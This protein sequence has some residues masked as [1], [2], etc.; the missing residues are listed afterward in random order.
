MKEEKRKYST[1]SNLRYIYTDMWKFDK[2]LSIFAA[3][4]V[5]LTVASN[6]VVIFL[7]AM[8]IQM[9]ELQFSPQDMIK[10]ILI[11]FSLYGILQAVYTYFEKRNW[12][13]YIEYRGGHVMRIITRKCMS[14]DYVQ[15][16]DEK[17]QKLMENATHAVGGND[18]GLEGILRTNIKVA[19][20]SIG[21]VLY[22]M[23]I[24]NIHYL[25][26]CML[27]GISAIQY[28]CYGFAKRYE[29]SNRDK[30]AKL[31]VTKR[32]F[33]QQAYDVAA[34]KDI[35]LYQ[36]QDWLSKKYQ[37]ANK[38]YQ[39]L[40]GKERMRYFAND[41][42]GLFLQLVRDGVCYIYLIKLL[43][44]GMN[45]SS[46][47]FYIGVVAGFSAYFNE[48]TFHVMELGRFH[49]SID[50]MREFFCLDTLF[51]HGEGERLEEAVKGI[52]V[53]F[54]HVSFAYPV[55]EKEE[56][57]LE[58]EP[59]FILNDISFKIKQGEKLALVGINGAGKTTIV[60]LICGFYRPTKGHVYINGIDIEKLD[61]DNYHKQLAVVFQESFIPSFSIEENVTC[62]NEED[63]D[64]ESCIKALQMA[65]L[66]EKVMSLPKKEKT[67]INKDIEKD[68]IQLSG[69]ESQKLLLA[70]ALYKEFK[71]LLLDE[72]TAALDAIAESEIYQKYGEVLYEKTAL[73]ISHRLASTRFCDKILF[74]EN[75]KIVEEGTHEQL[76]KREGGY[77]YMFQV[78]SKYYKEE[79]DVNQIIME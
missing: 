6:F 76:M 7:P 45:V 50:F 15:L 17:V 29:H 75:G 79:K 3:I 60:K 34:G 20:G 40:I 38:K 64:N 13:Q 27:F 4:E 67:S 22:A 32:Y 55:N 37:E 26:V 46:F 10:R 66:L 62:L 16:E 5:I 59:K 73:F 18:W 48:I 21:L 63:G 61:L 54:D 28:V 36:L 35:R 12:L 49:K 78:Q 42:V 71:L 57:A 53:E 23:F 33:D 19:V 43:I 51:H 52:E 8:V 30:K 11:V 68:G 44:E 70:R 56:A 72:P 74:L 58:E 41:L 69:G 24:S 25:I 14:I 65:G 31:S 9:L 1:F 77:A 2:S 47:V 39:I